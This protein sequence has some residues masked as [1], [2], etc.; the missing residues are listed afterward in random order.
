[1]LFILQNSLLTNF[2]SYGEFQHFI[3]C[4]MLMSRKNY[5]FVFNT[6]SNPQSQQIL[7]IQRDFIIFYRKFCYYSNLILFYQS[8]DSPPPALIILKTDGNISIYL[9]HKVFVNFIPLI[10]SQS[11]YLETFLLKFQVLL[12]SSF[13]KLKRKNHFEII[14][15]FKANFIMGVN[16][17]LIHFFIPLII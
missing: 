9:Y 6:F 2:I 8:F 10:H 5:D 12:S 7:K 16:V 3:F 14:F 11:V 15:D 13:K 4:Q 1:M 17:V